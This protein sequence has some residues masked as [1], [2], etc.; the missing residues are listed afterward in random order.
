[1]KK[2]TDSQVAGLR[3]LAK[4]PA[5]FYDLSR[6]GSAG[7]TAAWLVAQGL[8]SETTDGGSKTWQI[9]EAGSNALAGHIACHKVPNGDINAE[10]PLQSRNG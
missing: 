10:G 6:A 2:L 3:R 7:T 8:A 4:G 9:T 5:D 1:M